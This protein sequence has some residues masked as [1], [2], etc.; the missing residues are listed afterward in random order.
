MPSFPGQPDPEVLSAIGGASS[1][2]SIQAQL[3]RTLGRGLLLK[4]QGKK[5]DLPAIYKALGGKD[6]GVTA[7]LRG[8]VNTAFQRLPVDPGV[9]AVKKQAPQVVP[10]V[11][12][13]KS[14]DAL[15]SPLAKVE[16]QAL[17]TL[18]VFAGKG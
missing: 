15:T 1:G 6:P 13:S 3:E 17:H 2:A 10:R 18:A 16:G 8:P 9:K 14:V 7:M 12:A 5:A 4:M 11:K